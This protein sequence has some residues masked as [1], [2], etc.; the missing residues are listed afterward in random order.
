LSG[1]AQRAGVAEN[2]CQMR[3]DEWTLE[4]PI[5]RIDISYYVVTNGQC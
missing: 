3:A 4:L 1:V 5:E 2:R